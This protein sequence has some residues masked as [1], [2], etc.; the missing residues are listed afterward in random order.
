MNIFIYEKKIES[1]RSMQL[2]VASIYATVMLED[3][4]AKVGKRFVSDEVSR[5]QIMQSSK[6]QGRTVRPTKRLTTLWLC[7]YRR[8]PIEKISFWGKSWFW[9]ECKICRRKIASMQ[10][11]RHNLFSAHNFSKYFHL[12]IYSTVY[13]DILVPKRVRFTTPLRVVCVQPRVALYNVWYSHMFPTSGKTGHV[14]LKCFKRTSR[15][16]VI[17][18]KIYGSF[19]HDVR[20]NH[21][22]PSW[23]GWLVYFRVS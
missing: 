11:V 18:Y 21:W 4:N 10:N 6:P 1:S 3:A 2:F 15:D 13:I 17:Y 14:S 16:C 7:R 9:I 19:P 22:A 23:L 8:W 20:S 5:R 12:V